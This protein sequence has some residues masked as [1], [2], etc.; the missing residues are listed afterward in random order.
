MPNHHLPYK[1]VSHCAAYAGFK[2]H[3]RAKICHFDVFGCFSM[4]FVRIRQLEIFKRL[5]ERF[6]TLTIMANDVDKEKRML[7]SINRLLLTKF[8]F[9]ERDLAEEAN[10]SVEEARDMLE[11][12]QI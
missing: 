10:V 3:T 4:V 5:T 12:M 1:H 6:I 7:N 9:D 11:S 2:I 8:T